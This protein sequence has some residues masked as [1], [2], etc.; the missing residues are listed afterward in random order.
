MPGKRRSNRDRRQTKPKRPGARAGGP[1]SRGRITVRQVPGQNAFELVYP[2]C[3][4]RRKEDMEEVRAM[5]D[6]G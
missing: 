3:G 4:A 6:A 1:A 5:L 2:P